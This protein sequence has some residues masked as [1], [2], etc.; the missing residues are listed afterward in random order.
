MMQP[1]I[2]VM[3]VEDEALIAM[4]LANLLQDAGYEIVGPFSKVETGVKAAG[5]EAMIEAALL[6]VNLG[7]STVFPVADRLAERNI[8]IVFMTGYG[9]QGLPEHYK[10]WQVITKPYTPSMVTEA[11]ARILPN[12]SILLQHAG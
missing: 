12:S 5:T 6:D 9:L 8:P 1:K 7:R 11:L 2:R 10:A 3:I 4:F